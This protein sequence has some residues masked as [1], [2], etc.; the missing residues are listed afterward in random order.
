MEYKDFRS[1][2]PYNTVSM[3]VD[4]KKVLKRIEDNPNWDLEQRRFQ[5][6]VDIHK[7]RPWWEAQPKEI[8]A[9]LA[10]GHC[11]NIKSILDVGCGDGRWVPGVFSSYPKISYSGVELNKYHIDDCRNRFPECDRILGDFLELP[12]QKR[13]FDLILFGGVFNPKMDKL[14]EESIINK[15]KELEPRFILHTF[16]YT[17]SGYPP[18]LFMNGY[19]EV[20]SYVVPEDSKDFK[21]LVMAHLFK[22]DV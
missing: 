15:A 10:A 2:S 1:K 20:D 4:L 17:R 21:Q 5:A 22:R 6:L 19:H 16:D 18:W 13:Q 7:A 12:F 14:R 11:K 9:W 3:N 8:C